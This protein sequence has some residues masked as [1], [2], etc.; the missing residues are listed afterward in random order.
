MIKFRLYLV[1][2][3]FILLVG[4]Q[5]NK[6]LN[7]SISKYLYLNPQKSLEFGLEALSTDSLSNSELY[8]T[9]YL[10]GQNLYFT[11]IV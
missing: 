7:D 1:F 11:G 6:S 5:N 8:R 10:F 9:H 4:A 3:F 2:Q